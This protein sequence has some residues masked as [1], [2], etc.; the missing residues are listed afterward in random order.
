MPS[1]IDK[2]TV[3][4]GADASISICINGLLE[5]DNTQCIIERT[6]SFATQLSEQGF[7]VHILLDLHSLDEYTEKAEIQILDWLQNGKFDKLAIVGT[8]LI[9][10]LTLAA[11]A[12]MTG[13]NIEFFESNEMATKWLKD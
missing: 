12:K 2:H 10:K 11:T 8:D 5:D 7:P 9:E 13:L 4:L 1:I 3:A 6:E